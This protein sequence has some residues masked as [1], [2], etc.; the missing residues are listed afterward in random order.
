MS[1]LCLIEFQKPGVIDTYV[2]C[3]SMY[4][5][6]NRY[7]FYKTLFPPPLFINISSILKNTLKIKII[8]NK[9]VK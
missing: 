4:F 3:I 8:N 7:L 9:G 5:T 2:E 6:Q 1:R